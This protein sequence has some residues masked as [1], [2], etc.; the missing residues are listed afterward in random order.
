LWLEKKNKKK[1]PQ[2]IGCRGLLDTAI[3]LVVARP[4]DYFNDKT[5]V[6]IRGIP[7][8]HLAKDGEIVDDL[9]V[10]SAKVLKLLATG[11]I[12]CDQGA[13]EQQGNATQRK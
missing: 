10:I 4:Q 12:V 3:Q 6:G 7:N 13:T 11:C 2:A 8:S 9:S 5:V 1:I